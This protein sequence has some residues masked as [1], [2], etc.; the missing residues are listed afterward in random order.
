MSA[1]FHA[2]KFVHVLELGEGS[3][4][5]PI[6][7]TKPTEPAAFLNFHEVKPVTSEPYSP[8]ELST[9]LDNEE[10]VIQSAWL[11]K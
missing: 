4:Q 5:K 6:K 11:L 2:H 9:Y 7:Q 1:K 3:K 8:K 10:E